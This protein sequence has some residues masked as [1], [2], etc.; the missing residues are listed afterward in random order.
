[1]LILIGL[2]I[3]S[4]SNDDDGKNPE[5][6]DSETVISSELYQNAPSDQLIISSLEIE[7]DCLEI[8]FGAGGCDGRTW[9]IQLIDSGDILESNPPQRNL[10]LSLKDEELCEAF[11]TRELTFDISNLQVDGNQV[12][13]NIINSDDNLLYEY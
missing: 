9:E 13:L 8:I 5:N 10:R 1:M 2:T 7:S 6:C 11:I 12:M 4:C 3:W